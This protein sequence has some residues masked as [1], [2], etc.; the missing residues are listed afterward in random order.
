MSSWI[1][2]EEIRQFEYCPRIIYYRRVMCY[3]SYTSKLMSMGKQFHLMRTTKKYSSKKDTKTLYDYYLQ[4]ETLKLS[5]Y[6]DMIRIRENEVRIVE[7]KRFSNQSIQPRNGHILQAVFSSIIAEKIFNLPSFFIELR[8]WRGINSKM[9]ITEKM[10]ENVFLIIQN[11][12]NM[13]NDELIPEPTLHNR[14]CNVCEYWK[15]C[16]RV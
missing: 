14:K 10:K 8:Y 9:E 15:V 13:I 4:D 2:A 7:L 11:I 1:H 6:A 3:P 16:M 12:R 5:S